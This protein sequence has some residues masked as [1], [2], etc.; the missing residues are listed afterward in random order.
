MKIDDLLKTVE[1]PKIYRREGKDCYYDTYRKKL[2][3]ITPE[4]TVRQ[5]VAALFERQ[6]SVPRDM[7]SL[8]VP[9][10]HYVK[11]A[12]GR[13]DIIIHAIDE[14]NENI[15]PIAIIECKREEVFLTDKAAGQAIR[16]CD[17]IGGRYIAITNGL[18]LQFAAYEEASD[19]YVFLEEILS[20]GQMVNSEY[21]LPKVREE[22]FIRFTLDE[23]KNQKRISDYNEAGAWIFGQGTEEKLR[24]FAVNFYQALLD[25]S[26]RLPIMKR[27]SFELVEDI[28]R[29]CMDYSNAGGG[30]YN[31]IYRAFLVKDRFGETQIVSMS[32][33]GTDADFRGENRNS[34]TSLTVAI[35]RFK[36]S[37]NSLQYNVDRFVR[38]LPGGQACFSHNGQISSFKKADVVNMVSLNGDGLTVGSF[39][40]ELGAIDVDKVLFLDDS[41]VSELVYHFIEYTLLR[42]EIRKVLPHKAGR[43]IK[44]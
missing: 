32:V 29:R 11:G 30:H 31:G 34:Y 24:T 37:H 9:M 41:D 16:Y 28:G 22:K 18:E 39:G 1:L 20:Y 43:K 36:T 44:V 8:E 12:S 10:S 35:D 40:I 42:E 14:E 15:Y 5:K 4:E 2:I 17:T 38:L 3:E 6:Y 23:L 27:R 25:T 19:S 26:H 7:I 33:F 21:L 13:A